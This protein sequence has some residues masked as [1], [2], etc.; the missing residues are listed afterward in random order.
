MG[1]SEEANIGQADPV[2]YEP[3][4]AVEMIVHQLE[5]GIPRLTLR[6]QLQPLNLVEVRFAEPPHPEAQSRDVGLMVVLLPRHPAQHVGMVE[7]I[8]RHEAR[9]VGDIISGGVT[10]RD[11][12][13]S[14]LKHGDAAVCV[15]GREELRCAGFALQEIVLPPLE[16][17]AGKRCGK[18]DLVAV[19]GQRIFVK[20]EF[21]TH[22][23]TSST[24]FPTWP[25]SSMRACAAAAS[26]SGKL[27]SM[28]GFSLPP[29][30]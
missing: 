7:A 3:V 26:A 24:I 27:L 21:L 1:V 14:D 10:L 12:A 30:T 29:S 5:R 22:Q 2:P 17:D 25:P 28:T 19:P 11:E 23:P 4:P 15:H 9:A 13:I 6:T 18:P 16:R 20:H 8:A